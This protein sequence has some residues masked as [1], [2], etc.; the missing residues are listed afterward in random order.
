MDIENVFTEAAE[1]L[2]NAELGRLGADLRDEAINEALRSRGTPVEVTASDV[3]R[4]AEHFRKKKDDPGYFRSAKRLLQGY[5][6]FGI[7]LI[8]IGVLAL[9]VEPLIPLLRLQ[10]KFGPQDLIRV[11]RNFVA[12]GGVLLLAVAVMR[13]YMRVTLR[14]WGRE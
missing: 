2:L 13:W 7:V 9:F 10:E 1:S 6:W 3:R 11:S 14:R 8:A 4:A 12:M 5:F